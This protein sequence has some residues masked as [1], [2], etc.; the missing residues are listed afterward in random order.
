MFCTYPLE[1]FYRNVQDNDGSQT[2]DQTCHSRG[3]GGGGGGGGVGY[4]LE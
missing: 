2:E 4:G 1:P 3:E